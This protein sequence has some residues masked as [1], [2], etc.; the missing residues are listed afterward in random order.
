MKKLN[1]ASI[2]LIITILMPFAGHSQT[3][4]KMNMPS[5]SKE[6]LKVVA[7]FEEE[8]PE[9]IPVV[10]GVLGYSITGGTAP[11]K[12]E[13]QQNGTTISKTDVAVV[14]PAK[15]DVLVLKVTDAG[16]CSST[17]SFNLKVASRIN[18]QPA[19]DDS[20][21]SIY[22]TVVDSYFNVENSAD[23]E[24]ATIRI[25]DV[26]G[27][28]LLQQSFTGSTQI[29]TNLPSGIYFVSVQSSQNHILKK[30]VKR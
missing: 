22:P 11:F 29:S 16:G 26:N 9:S 30:I 5:Q 4:V 21:I 2:L 6:Q 27:E 28:M 13:W 18:F 1:I 25:F 10:L 17:T 19:S 3:V 24:E 8:I 14:T 23:N 12:Y 7:L 20:S 15:G